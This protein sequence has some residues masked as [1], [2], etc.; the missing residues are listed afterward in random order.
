MMNAISKIAIAGALAAASMVG[1]ASEALAGKYA[2]VACH[3][4]A[5][6]VVGP[7]WNEVAEK[8]GKAGTTPAQLA[9]SIKKGGSG[10]WGAMPMPPQTTL[11]D[12]DAIA[13]ATW[14][15]QRRA[16]K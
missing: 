6:R 1:H 4:A 12:G 5:Q 11:S 9:A 3:Q 14:I 2:C 13:L 8:H 7:S 10:K 15:L 16:T